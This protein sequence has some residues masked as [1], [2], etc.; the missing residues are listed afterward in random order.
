M[1]RKQQRREDK[2]GNEMR[3]EKRRDGD[4]VFD[5]TSVLWSS[6]IYRCTSS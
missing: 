2:G 5:I 4:F 3:E 6:I 1:E